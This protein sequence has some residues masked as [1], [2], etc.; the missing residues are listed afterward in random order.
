MT[1]VE[2]FGRI[3]RACACAAEIAERV[4]AH[5]PEGVEAIYDRYEY[6]EEKREALAQW[7]AEIIRIA[8]EEDVS[9][10]LHIPSELS[11]EQLA[12]R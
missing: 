12:G 9:Q 4:I 1:Y 8:V 11:D 5:K 7:E 3:W 10:F 2:S 6:L